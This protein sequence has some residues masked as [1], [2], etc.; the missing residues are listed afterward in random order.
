[1]KVTKMNTILSKFKEWKAFGMSNQTYLVSTKEEMINWK[2]LF[3]VS[4]VK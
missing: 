3:T 4:T 2:K 1:M